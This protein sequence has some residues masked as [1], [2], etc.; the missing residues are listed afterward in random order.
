LPENCSQ[1][2]SVEFFVAWNGERLL[3]AEWAD[4]PQLYVATRLG[5]YIEAKA[6]QDVDNLRSG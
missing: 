6:L 4:T 1:G 5:L 3:F 2:A